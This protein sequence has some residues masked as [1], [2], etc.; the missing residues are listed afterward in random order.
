MQKRSGFDN[1]VAELSGTYASLAT[2][3]RDRNA[4]KPFRAAMAGL[5][6]SGTPVN[7]LGMGDSKVEGAV[8]TLISK[9]YMNRLVAMLRAYTGTTGVGVFSGGP[10]AYIP[11]FYVS[12]FPSDPTFVL[13]AGAATY[14]NG[15]GIGRKGIL[16][17]NAGTATLT[18]PYTS[19]D[20]YYAKFNNG[21]TLTVKVDGVTVTT[22]NTNNSGAVTDGFKYN[23][24]AAGA[25]GTHAI[26]VT[27]NN[28][29]I[30]NGIYPYNG[31][32]AT[33][34]R[35]FDGGY[36]GATAGIFQGVLTQWQS[37]IATIQPQLVVIDLGTND[38]AANAVPA[39][40]QSNLTDIVTTI[41]AQCT[42]PPSIVLVVP[43]Q[44]PDTF[45]YPWSQYVAA[46]ES[47]ATADGSIAVL[48]ARNGMYDQPSMPVGMG[49]FGGDNIHP[50]DKGHAMLGDALYAFLLDNRGGI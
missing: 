15:G 31:D 45:T 43:P 2:E 7:I 5:I 6:A 33:G 14:I 10:T 19:F 40:Y 12:T 18:V 35:Y 16:I 37:S 34:I 32:E 42:L 28:N 17:P 30:I 20:L 4:L 22:L 48:Y 21:G 39:T 13:A 26:Q 50:T 49:L 38:V 8:A 11:A 29:S 23:S 46:V 25:L 41:R 3:Q 36:T 27:A 9:R 24:G 47:L 44:R 1:S